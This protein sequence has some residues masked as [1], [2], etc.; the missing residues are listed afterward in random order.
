MDDEIESQFD[1]NFSEICEKMDFTDENLDTKSRKDGWIETDEFRVWL[2][3]YLIK[4]GI[5]N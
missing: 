4:S 5:R 3:D 1:N 2:N